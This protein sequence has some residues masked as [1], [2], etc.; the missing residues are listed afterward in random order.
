MA[1]SASPHDVFAPLNA[2]GINLHAVFSLVEL[3]PDV[4]GPLEM[5]GL[6]LG[7]HTQLIL[8]G[9]QGRAFWDALQCRGMHGSDP[10]ETFVTECVARWMTESLGAQAW[11][12]VFPG[13]HRVG[14]Q[15]LGEWAGWHRPSPFW[16]GVDA[17]WGSWFAYRAVVLADTSL[18][19]TP[20]SGRP[21]P[22]TDCRD[23]PCVGACPAG[24]LADGSGGHWKLQACLDER[25]RP[26]S[27]CQDRC[28]ARIA[29]P[30]GQDHRYS[31][32][33]M[34][35]HYL[36]SLAALRAYGSRG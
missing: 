32:A 19:L 24:A 36:Q 1:S 30:V 25:L 23:R 34:R 9:H 26:G 13:P 22:C 11:Q 14:L 10:V 31:D 8:L 12:Q 35:Y 5:A 4:L 28:L 33:Q 2:Q 18:P 21:S 29:C 7:R 20:R 6:D 17:E 27:A 16:V 3:P 15:R